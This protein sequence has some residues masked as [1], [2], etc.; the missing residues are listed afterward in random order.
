MNSTNSNAKRRQNRETRVSQNQ[1]QH[2][3]DSVHASSASKSTGNDAEITE[4]VPIPTQQAANEKPP[5]EDGAT[6]KMTQRRARKS[7]VPQGSHDI[8]SPKKRTSPSPQASQPPETR[9][10]RG[11]VESQT[12]I[13]TATMRSKSP[14]TKRLSRSPS[15]VKPLASPPSLSDSDD[16]DRKVPA[17]R[18]DEFIASSPKGG[19]RKALTPASP[20]DLT[21][22][23]CTFYS[24]S[25]DRLVTSKPPTPPPQASNLPPMIPTFSSPPSVPD[26]SNKDPAE[27]AAALEAHR[28]SRS[29]VTRSQTRRDLNLLQMLFSPSYQVTKSSSSRQASVEGDSPRRATSSSQ[30]SARSSVMD[31]DASVPKD[32]TDNDENV[33][34]PQSTGEHHHHHAHME[35][36]QTDE[37][38]PEQEGEEI[39]DR[40][41]FDPF[42]FIRSLPPYTDLR[43]PAAL[44]K[45]SRS[46]PPITLV[47]DLDET[48]V[49]CST[50]PLEHFDLNFPIDFNDQHFEVSGRL[51]PHWKRFLEETS[52][53]FEVIVFTASQRVYAD[54]LLDMLDPTGEF[55]KHRLFREHCL[56]LAGNYLK[57]LNILGRDLRK[58]VIVDNSPQAFGY[59]ISNGIPITSWYEDPVRLFSLWTNSFVEGQGIIGCIGLFGND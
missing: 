27:L 22:M 31:D 46:S 34:P 7:G 21:R 30:S 26:F 23:R 55:I 6:T 36:D 42:W 44:P 50:S 52:L 43:R 8:A 9:R 15:P 2:S 13:A 41:E 39:E 37:D 28:N 16:D 57:D 32:H 58:T 29:M 17:L 20:P 40:D 59:Q 18:N 51:R 1:P 48:L 56:Y 49:H 10:V 33:A 35:V 5:I 38:L 12:L 45:K 14:P 25:A 19:R 3:S 53:K 4:S 24:E 54:K 11:K 47:L